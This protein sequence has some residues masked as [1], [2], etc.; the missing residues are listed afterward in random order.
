MTILRKL[1][2]IVAASMSLASCANSGP[3]ME[4]VEYVDLERFMGDWYVIGRI[5]RQGKAIQPQGL[6]P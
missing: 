6:R 3:E 2:L 5:R 4:T 1:A